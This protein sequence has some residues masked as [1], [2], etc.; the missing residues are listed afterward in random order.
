[1]PAAPPA[2]L[3]ATGPAVDAADD[4]FDVELFARATHTIVQSH[5]AKQPM[6][7][8]LAV[9]AFTASVLAQTM[10]R[11]VSCLLAL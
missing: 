2:G 4:D 6:K 10:V 7:V 8:A 3:L 1:M 11:T 5:H 9:S